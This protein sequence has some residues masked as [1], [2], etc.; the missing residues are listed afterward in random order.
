[1]KA[2][3][4]IKMENMASRKVLLLGLFMSLSLSCKPIFLKSV[5]L[6]FT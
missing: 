5:R 2:N 6:I 1:M 4:K 3:K